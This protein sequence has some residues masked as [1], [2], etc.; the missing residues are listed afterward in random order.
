MDLGLRRGRFSMP[1]HEIGAQRIFNSF[2]D[3]LAAMVN[4]SL[5]EDQNT[6]LLRLNVYESLPVPRNPCSNPFH[7]FI[8]QVNLESNAGLSS[9][10]ELELAI[11]VAS[12]VMPWPIPQ[13]TKAL[14]KTEKKC[15]LIL[16][17]F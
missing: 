9:I 13:E 17:W 16:L 5:L 6:S 7:F 12:E 4:S 3:L 14:I 11:A 8:T 15:L 2:C 10:W 1:E